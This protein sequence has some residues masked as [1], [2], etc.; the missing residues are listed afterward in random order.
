ML[1]SRPDMT[2]ISFCEKLRTWDRFDGGNRLGVDV[3]LVEGQQTEEENLRVLVVNLDKNRLSD[4]EM[5]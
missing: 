1:F 4:S 3:I 2:M 5:A